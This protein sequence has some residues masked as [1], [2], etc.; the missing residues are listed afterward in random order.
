MTELPEGWAEASIAD[1][2]GPSGL[3][4]DGDW[5]ERKDQDSTGEVRLTQLADVGEAT[6]RDRSNRRLTMAT[7]EALRCTFLKR[8]DVLVAR[9]PDPLGRACL[10]P[11]DPGPAV[12]VV[13]VCVIRPSVTGAAPRWLMWFLNA[14]RA[15]F[16][17]EALQSGTTRKRVSRRNLGTIVLPVPPIGEQERIVAVIEEQFSRPDAAEAGLRG[18][19]RHAEGYSSAVLSAAVDR[20]DANEVRVADLADFVTDGDHR[21]PKRVPQG[22]PHLTAKHIRNGRVTI[23]GCTFV[24]PE[25]FEQTRRRYEPCAGDVIVTCVGTIGETAVVPEGLTFSA[26]R[27]LAA[28]RT[29]PGVD[30]RFVRIALSAP[31]LQQTIRNASGSTAQPHLYLRDLRELVLRLPTLDEQ[32]SIVAEVERQLSILDSLSAAIDRALDRSRR[33]RRAILERAFT[34]RLVPQDPADEPAS[35]LLERIAAERA[36]EQPTRRVRRRAEMQAT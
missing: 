1:I 28:I 11:G 16:Q 22:V 30:A 26:D 3:F 17:I 8:G 5:V 2:I 14:P 12:T 6:W 34:G 36:A 15:R 32:R 29:I 20:T 10:F 31:R 35:V 7:A 23:D 4:A 13:D 19:A 9:M 25:G 21:P 24:S 27:N 18:A 33:L